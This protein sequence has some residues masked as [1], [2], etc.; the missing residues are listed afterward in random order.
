[1]GPRTRPTRAALSAVGIAIG[2]AA[3]VAVIG[4]PAS[5]TAQVQAEFESWGANVIE[6]YPGSDRRSGEKIPLPETA[7][8]MV[9]RIWPVRTSLTLRS[10]PDVGVYRNDKMMAGETGGLTAMV[11]EGDLLGTLNGHLAEGR[12][13]DE[14][15]TRLPTTVIGAKVSERLRVGLGG[16]VWI[17]QSWWAVIG[18][19]ER[20]PLYSS[21]LD[22]VA[23]LAPEWAN[24]TFGSVPITQIL[25]NAYVGQADAVHAVMAA[26]VNPANPAG[27]EVS[28]P[29]DYAQAQDYF[30]EIIR[31]L[32]L[33]LGA[34][35]LLVGAIGIA[36]TMVVSVME[37]RGEIGLR[38]ALGARTGQ[39]GLQFVLEAAVIG[40]LGGILGVIFGVYA[41]FCFTAYTA[42]AFAVPAWVFLAG[43]AASI[44]IGMLAGLYPS[45]KAARQSPTAA[46]RTV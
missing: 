13:F 20:L 25:A 23:F 36:N 10:V 31:S 45:L 14:A 9:E 4:I 2:I 5:L 33:G 43:P 19:L 15:S 40:C 29:S 46:L 7:P 28:K 44:A 32:A 26:T 39:I 8:A 12:W 3:L 38:R 27:V 17:G 30:L 21:Q 37:R 22:N 16:R 34:I 42:I 11:A 18:V 35:A 24:K 41:V 6:V 1:L